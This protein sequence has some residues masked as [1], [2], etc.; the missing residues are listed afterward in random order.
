[1]T[2]TI[3]KTAA[4]VILAA[5]AMFG[6]ATTTSAQTPTIESLLQMIADLTAQLN[7]LQGGSSNTT[8]GSCGVTTFGYT[9]PGMTLQQGSTGPAVSALQMALNNYAGANLVTDGIFG[10]GTAQAVRNFQTSR[11]L[12]VD[13]VFGPASA[14]ALV[15]ESAMTTPC[16]TD[17]NTGGTGTT[18][19]SVT[20]SGDEGLFEVMDIFSGNTEIKLGQA[21]VVM[22]F[23]VEAFD[24]DIQID[25]VDFFFDKRPWLY[26]S[27]VNL[28]IDGSKVSTLSG[29]NA[30]TQSGSEWRARFNSVGHVINQDDVSEFA[31]QL[32][33]PSSLAGTRAADDVTAELRPEA[34]RGI[35]GAGFTLTGPNAQTITSTVDFDDVFGEG[36][37]SVSLSNNSPQAANIVLNATSQ[38]NGVQVLVF[39]VEAVDSNVEVTDVWVSLDTD[40]YDLED[41]LRRAYLFRGNNQIRQTATIDTIDAAEAAAT[42]FAL[43]DLVVKFANV[44]FDISEGSTQSFNVRLDFFSGNAIDN[45]GFDLTTLSVGQVLVV[46]DNA[47]FVDVSDD[48]TVNEDHNLLVEGII[49]ER[50]GNIA[51]MANDADV[52]VAKYTF[53]LDITA[54]ESDFFISR[55]ELIAFGDGTTLGE[56]DEV[57]ASAHDILS[58]EISS[59][60]SLNNANNTWR[61]NKG[62]TKRFTVEVYVGDAVASGTSRVTLN[63]INYGPAVN[64]ATG[65]TFTM[66]LPNFESPTMFIN[67]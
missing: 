55:D 26:F 54:Y 7:Q 17:N 32:V 51:V 56:D 11:G 35:D 14:S 16:P 24:S 42:P 44:D 27:E 10:G 1:M 2:N 66:G 23:E 13:A 29:S 20:L 28:W 36:D 43:N 60:A 4:G 67:N 58:V 8:G 47:D 41:V 64:N 39:D 61:I 30:F 48:I 5:V 38:T 65:L 34:L 33:V 6:V 40:T 15:A 18:G 46:A 63:A 9:A 25:R 37:I 52:T 49:V 59:N 62:E 45:A 12:A 22:E 21:E 19:G 53:E 50:V 3:K 31:L 57:V